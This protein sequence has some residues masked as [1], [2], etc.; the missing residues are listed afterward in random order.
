M[1][2]A[3]M[4]AQKQ[5]RS[6]APAEYCNYVYIFLNLVDTN[7]R[8]IYNKTITYERSLIYSFDELDSCK[9]YPK[10]Q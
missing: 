8:R 9:G 10:P 2:P 6:P 1:D 3:Q 7:I 5:R 4:V